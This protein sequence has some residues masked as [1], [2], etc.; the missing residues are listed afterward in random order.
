[1]AQSENVFQPLEVMPNGETRSRITTPEGV[2]YVLTVAPP[3]ATS[4]QNA[5]FHKGLIESYQV[6]KG[7]IA[8]AY[9]KGGGHYKLATLKK[10]EEVQVGRNTPH[11]IFLFPGAIIFTAK[12][13]I[14]VGNP[15]KG[16][17]DWYE[18]DPLFDA[19]SKGVSQ[20]EIP[21][22]IDQST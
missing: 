5:H 10:G 6:I 17:S 22:F 9:D 18:A 12:Q 21:K 16:G 8:I 2:G 4:W 3:S 14:P 15:E 20:E 11:N 1:M 7:E 19:W 13:G